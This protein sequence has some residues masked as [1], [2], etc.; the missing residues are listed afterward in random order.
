VRGIARGLSWA[1]SGL[2]RTYAFAMAA[3][4]VGVAV[5]FILVRR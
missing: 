2:V 3:G 5:T 4:V 1:Q